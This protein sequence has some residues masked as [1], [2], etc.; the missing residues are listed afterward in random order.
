MTLCCSTYN[1]SKGMWKHDRDKPFLKDD[2]EK[3]NGCKLCLEKVRVNIRK[4]SF[5]GVEFSTE[6]GY[7]GRLEILPEGFQHWKEPETMGG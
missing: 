2:I 1:S 6:A 5:L 4:I 3:N 7:S